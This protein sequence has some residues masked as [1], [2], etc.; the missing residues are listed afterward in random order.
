MSA[1]TAL[2]VPLDAQGFNIQNVVPLSNTDATTVASDPTLIKP[3]GTQAQLGH[4]FLG[5]PVDHAHAL[6]D[7]IDA[8]VLRNNFRLL[9]RAYVQQGFGIPAGLEDEFVASMGN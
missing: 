5:A 4:S 9:L 6:P 2:Q 8:V 1:E 7:S 3:I